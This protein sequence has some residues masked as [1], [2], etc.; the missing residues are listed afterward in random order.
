MSNGIDFKKN[1]VPALIAWVRRVTGVKSAIWVRP[2]APRP[3]IYPQAT[4]EVLTPRTKVG[5]RDSVTHVSGTTFCLGGQRTIGIS[6]SIYSKDESMYF[7]ATDLGSKL[8]DSLDDPNELELLRA[9]GLAVF[10][11]NDVVDTTDLLETGFEPRASLDI[12]FGIA[13]NREVDL[14]SIDSVEFQGNYDGQ[15]DEIITVS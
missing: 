5:S 13:S 2:N 7:E 10:I 8:Q 1:Q 11:V 12:T 3:N 9:A 6:I 15:D 14:G 4:L